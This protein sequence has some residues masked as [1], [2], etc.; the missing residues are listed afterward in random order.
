MKKRF[1]TVLAIAAIVALK[2]AS[3]VY[4]QDIR[5]ELTPEITWRIE[6]GTLFISGKGVVPTTTS[7]GI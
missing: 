4:G 3:I 7:L 5:G 1:L 6:N 2:P